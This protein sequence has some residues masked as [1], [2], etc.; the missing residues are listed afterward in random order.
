MT[1]INK[2]LTDLFDP[3]CA[4]YCKHRQGKRCQETFKDAT[5]ER[6]PISQWWD[7]NDFLNDVDKQVTK[8]M[9]RI[10]QDRTNVDPT[11]RALND[12]L[13]FLD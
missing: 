6:C 9:K 4:E 5:L 7:L 2:R 11:K 1:H 10:Q 8:I 3:F 13:K 12:A